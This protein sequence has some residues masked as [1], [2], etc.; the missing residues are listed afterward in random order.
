MLGR[1]AL[2][3]L[4]LLPLLELYLLVELGRWLGSG[5]SVVALVVLTAI[6]GGAFARVQG[7]RILW[8]IRR[9]LSEGRVPSEGLIDGLFVLV[10]GV[11]LIVPGILTDL[12]GL[13]LLLPFTRRRL[14][15]GLRRRMAEW[16]RTGSV[17]FFIW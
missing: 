2:L 8:N 17:R 9:D 13:V 12:A 16:V 7:L 10:G 4:I 3:L 5:W 14:K 15:E 6:A 11:L 1:I